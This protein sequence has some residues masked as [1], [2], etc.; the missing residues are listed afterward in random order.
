M[1]QIL[2][3]AIA[4]TV[5]C[6]ALLHNSFAREPHVLSGPIHPNPCYSCGTV[7]SFDPVTDTEKVVHSFQDNGADGY[8]PNAGLVE[9]HGK[10][11]GTTLFGGT[12]CDGNCGTIYSIDIKTGSE[13]VLYSF[14]GGTDGSRP[15]AGLHAVGHLLYGTTVNGGSDDEGTVFSFDPVTRMETVVY[16]FLQNGQDGVGPGASLIDVGGILYGTTGGGG[17]YGS[18]TVFSVNPTSGAET[19]LH[20][21]GSGEDGADPSANV[22]VVGGTLYGTTG[23]GGADSRGT[24]F[25]LDLT[26]G[27]EAVVY[28]FT[29]GDDGVGPSSGLIKLQDRLYGATDGENTCFGAMSEGSIYEIDTANGA[30]ISLHCFS[31]YTRDGGLLPLGNLIADNK[32]LYGTTG[33]GGAYKS[34]AAAGCGTIF[35]MLKSGR[36]KTLYSFCSQANCPDGAA[37]YGSMINVGSMLYGTTLD[38][39]SGATSPAEHRDGE[40]SQ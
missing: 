18:G 29:G 26:T 19:V 33:E 24:V 34:C 36:T 1:K 10:L 3:S 7:F 27:V 13:K 5:I 23:S 20:S 28:S 32:I 12:S 35:S 9:F 8:W 11:Y 16:S 31:D 38:G 4:G 14:L 21:F 22:T 30:E 39:G 40:A 37:P 25:S 15:T 2:L 17:T 6:V